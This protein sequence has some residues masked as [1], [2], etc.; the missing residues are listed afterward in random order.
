MMNKRP[1]HE[2]TVPVPSLPVGMGKSG[3]GQKPV[4]ARLTAF[5]TVPVPKSIPTKW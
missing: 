2:L 4:T 1:E 3:N 5:F